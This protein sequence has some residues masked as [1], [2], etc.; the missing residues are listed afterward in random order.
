MLR[1]PRRNRKSAAIRN[2]VAE[3]SLATKNFI[4]PLFLLEGSKKK[5]AVESMPGI[6]RLSLDAAGDRR[7][8][9]IRNLL[10]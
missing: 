5:I 8:H 9:E 10:L 7:V 1:R 2:M 6:F 3:T 4:F